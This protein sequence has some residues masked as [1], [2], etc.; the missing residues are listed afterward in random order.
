MGIYFLILSNEVKKERRYIF[1]LNFEIKIKY[2]YYILNVFDI[3]N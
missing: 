3:N 2:L 1:F